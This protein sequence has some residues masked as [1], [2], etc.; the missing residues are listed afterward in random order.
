LAAKRLQMRKIREILRLKHEVGLP[1]RSI[2]RAVH[3]SIGTVSEYLS[4][5]KELG[6]SWPLPTEVDDEQLEAVLFPSAEGK[7]KRQTPDFAGMHVSAGQGLVHS[8]GDGLVQGV[9]WEWRFE[10]VHFEAGVR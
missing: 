3:A 2:A 4:K 10:V 6:V 1:L 8:V 5:A 7:E 9:E